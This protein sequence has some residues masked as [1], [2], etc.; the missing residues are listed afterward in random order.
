MATVS[1]R[2]APQLPQADIAQSCERL[3]TVSDVCVLIQVAATFVYRHAA[4]LGAMKVG[5]HLRFR[6]SD[7]EAWLES[8]RMSASSECPA[9]VDNQRVRSYRRTRRADR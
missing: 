4:E 1:E 8:Q 9:R 3:L 7:V 6:R 5:S 2:G